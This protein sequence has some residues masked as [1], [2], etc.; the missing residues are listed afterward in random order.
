MPANTPCHV[1]ITFHKARDER[2]KTPNRSN[3]DRILDQPH[4]INNLHDD[5]VGSP[6]SATGTIAQHFLRHQA[7]PFINQVFVGYDFF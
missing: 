5:T 7:G 6:M 4:F 2:P 1:A 3:A